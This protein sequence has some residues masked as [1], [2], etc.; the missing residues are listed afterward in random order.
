MT[1]NDLQA[2]ESHLIDAANLVDCADPTEEP[3]AIA[4]TC[5]AIHAALGQ[6]TAL[7]D[8]PA[9]TAP[10]TSRG[11]GSAPSPTI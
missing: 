1:R 4:D 2:A 6:L 11:R 10:T 8:M 9:K 7:L 3:R 5:R